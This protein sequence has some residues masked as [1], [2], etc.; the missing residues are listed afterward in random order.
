MTLTCTTTLAQNESESNG[1]ERVF[2]N[3]QISRC[4]TATPEAVN[5][6][7]RTTLF[8]LLLLFMSNNRVF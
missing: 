2:Y 1:N 8:Q 4:G 5:A 7:H 6:I 3:P